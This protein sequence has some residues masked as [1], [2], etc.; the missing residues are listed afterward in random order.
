MTISN[1]EEIIE[2]FR[3]GKMVILVDDESRENEG[4]L[5]VA[6]DKVTA[7]QINFMTRHACGLIC[8]TL[9]EERCRQLGLSL[10]V[11]SNNSRFSTNFTV[12]IEAAR[13]VETGIS[14][15][16]RLTT[17]RAAVNP[18]AMPKDIISPG[19]IFPLMARP[20]GVL[21]RAGH[22]EAGVD[23]ARLAG[24]QPASVICE[25]LKPDGTMARLPDLVD[26]AREYDIKIS[27]VADLIRY[28][29]EREPT[30][31]RVGE[32]VLETSVGRFKAVVYH[33]IVEDEAHLALVKGPINSASTTLVRVH[34]ESGLYAVFREL[35]GASTWTI[36]QALER[37]QQAESGVL[38][39]LRYNESADAIIKSVRRADAEGR[40]FEFP[41]REAGDDLRMLGL[42]AQI[43]ADLG[44]RRMRVMGSPKRAHAL[45]GFNLEIVDYITD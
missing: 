2:D 13:G 34:V 38:V 25:V 39:I 7:E 18:D 42:G 35:Q 16:D 30:V 29:L 24:M 5:L 23:L 31:T 44:V 41:W 43:L 22:T 28:R 45:S 15:A 11:G 27:S 3:H 33:D 32:S 9:T 8:L 14:V 6:A 20:G 17:V 19:H 1:I 21:T 10:M 36:G 4:D 37:I 40:E 26:F 12:S